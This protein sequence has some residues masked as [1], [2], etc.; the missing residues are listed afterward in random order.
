M[1]NSGTNDVNI[2]DFVFETCLKLVSSDWIFIEK[3]VFMVRELR[4]RMSHAS[5][6]FQS[7]LR[8]LLRT[9]ENNLIID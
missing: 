1:V 3:V 4:N 8:I 7:R 9:R 2:S 5:F 6:Q